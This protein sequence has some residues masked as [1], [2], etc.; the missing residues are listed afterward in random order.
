MRDEST[1]RGRDAALR[2]CVTMTMLPRAPQTISARTLAARLAE[3]GWDVT[4]RT[5]ERDLH[6]LRSVFPIG[7]DAGHK[8]FGWSW[9]QEPRFPAS[10]VAPIDE[11]REPDA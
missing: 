11:V 10:R 8:P 6:R 9:L 4:V 5:V 3:A 1:P 2:L 7:L